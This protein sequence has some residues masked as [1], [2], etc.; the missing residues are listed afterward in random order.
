MPNFKRIIFAVVLGLLSSVSSS[1]TISA[2]DVHPIVDTVEGCLIGGIAGGKWLE[3]D[4]LAPM[5]KGGERYRLYTLAS[6]A[7]EAVGSNTESAGEPCNGTK[8]IKFSPETRGAIAVGGE[9]NALPRIP[10][11]VSTNDPIYRQ[12][13]AG[14]LRRNGFVRPKINIT[15]IIRIDL[16]GDGKEE[17]IVSA[18]HLAEG[19]S[20]DG[21][22]MAV[23]AKPGDYSLVFVRKIMRGRVRDIVLTEAYFPRKNSQPWTPT[24]DKVAAVLD[25]NGDGKMEIL[26]HGGYYEGSWSSVFRLDGEK[27]KNV[28]GCGCGA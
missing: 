27:F 12:V 22:P 17:V 20:V 4:E 2:Q 7:G 5:L 8:N 18:T 15:Q 3:A 25:L 19:L 23:H 1:L 26:L 21:G 28:F 16:E 9:W 13:V 24:Q 6:A 11:A 14:F 10:R